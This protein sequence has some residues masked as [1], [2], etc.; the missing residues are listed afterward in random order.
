MFLKGGLEM[1]RLKHSR[2][3]GK[4]GGRWCLLIIHHGNEAS[5]CVVGIFMISTVTREHNSIAAREIDLLFGA[6]T[7]STE[8]IVRTLF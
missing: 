3:L 2:M 7:M 4:K 6:S 8:S 5:I 1:K